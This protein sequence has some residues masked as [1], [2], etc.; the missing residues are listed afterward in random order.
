MSSTPRTDALKHAP[1]DVLFAHACQLERD[2]G[3]AMAKYANE[4]EAS[5]M[6]GSQ[7]SALRLQLKDAEERASHYAKKASLV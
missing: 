1:A 6:A 2:L 5:M 3:R 7:L 4:C